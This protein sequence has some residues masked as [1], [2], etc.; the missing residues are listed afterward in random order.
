MKRDKEIIRRNSLFRVLDDNI[1]KK[2]IT[3][4]APAGYGKTTLVSS[5]L[6]HRSITGIWI[7]I[8]AG[9][10]TFSVFFN[11]FINKFRNEKP[12]FGENFLS[13]IAAFNT[14]SE[15]FKN[16]L[17]VVQDLLSL[18]MEDLM[19]YF[20]EKV[21][22]VLDDFHL[23]ENQ[24][25]RLTSAFFE[26]LVKENIG[27]LQIFITSRTEPSVGLNR[28]KAKRELLS[29]TADDLRFTEQE[30]YE[31]AEKCY[32]G[33]AKDDFPKKLMHL[34]DGWVTGLHLVLQSKRNSFSSVE[35]LS[36]VVNESLY[37]FFMEEI[38]TELDDETKDLLLKTSQLDVFTERH[39][40]EI[41]NMSNARNIISNLLKRNIFIIKNEDDN[42]ESGK[43][44]YIYNDYFRKFL[45]DQY[46]IAF[47]SE[48]K[49]ENERKIALYF[50]NMG[51]H[52]IAIDRYIKGKQY[53]EAMKLISVSYKT[54]KEWDKLRRIELWLQSVPEELMLSHPEIVYMKAYILLNL[55]FDVK[56]ACELIDSAIDYVKETNM[57][58]KLALL[59]AETTFNTYELEMISRALG[60]AEIMNYDPGLNIRLHYI[61][62]KL[63][64]RSGAANYENARNELLE[65]L[66]IIEETD[67]NELKPEIFMILGNICQDT[68]EFEK[69]F[70]YR[71]RSQEISKNIYQK[72]QV[73][74]NLAGLQIHTGKYEDAYSTLAE[75][76][77]L[78]KKNSFT[79]LKR[80]LVK[81]EAN[82]YYECGDFETCYEKFEELIKIENSMNLTGF[83]WYN[84][85]MQGLQLHYSDLQEYALQKFDIAESYLSRKDKEKLILV[86][87]GRAMCL[88]RKNAEQNSEL[89]EKKLLSV[90]DY[91]SQN[92]LKVVVLQAA[93][94]LASYYLKT[95]HTETSQKY[96]KQAF[97]PAYGHDLASFFERELPFHRD[98]FDL[99]VT[100]GISRTLR[101]KV[102][103]SYLNRRQFPWISEK[104]RNRLAADAAKLTDLKLYP[105]GKAEIYLRGK[106]ISEEKWIRKKSKILLIFLMSDPARIHTKDE[107]MD[108][109]FD[110]MPA[111][112]ADVVY[113]S[114]IY[115]IR[116]A[117]RIYDIKSSK[118]KRSRD[119]S[120]DYNPQYILYEDKTLKLNPDF[121]YKTDNIEFEKFYE[122]SKLPVLAIEDK[123]KYSMSAIELYKGD[124]LPGY[125]DSW[126]EELRVKYK[127]M[128]ITLCEDLIKLLEAE[129]RFDEVIKYSELLLKE[130]KLND[131]AHFS[132][133]NAYTKLGN[134]NMA[135]SRFDLMLK[136]YA[137]ELGENPQP[138]TL[139]KIK[140][141]LSTAKDP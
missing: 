71:R 29:L 118:P 138:R 127:N 124:F 32:P 116:T 48:Q 114:A 135:K 49:K 85:L 104:C 98:L 108:I 111:D 44:E 25:S 63:L 81:T 90:Y 109:F 22:L 99:S 102:C 121:Y 132:L 91:Y 105:F 96:L 37:G 75:M 76:K 58:L 28:L 24:D 73:C 10:R 1:S 35:N 103:G 27:N 70:F 13:S 119:K 80:F 62:G 77:I 38:W 11:H 8:T 128:Y 122:N 60:T 65:A 89:I 20:S 21:V 6:N 3:V 9:N 69:S 68:G 61:R 78:Y 30:T 139:E 82:L 106:P 54:P 42:E 47:P 36:D 59:K 93:F 50:Q 19:N 83:L 40:I 129:T 112:K 7:G 34:L 33:K 43:T 56:N 134:M 53:R 64:Y 57:K 110:D 72:M 88:L 41:Y 136:I 92:N 101:R 84:Y 15:L 79:S 23:L 12:G 97:D 18:F 115:N 86:N 51:E 107:I 17:S 141:I 14:S 55:N 67:E 94:Y 130:D 2:V 120:F 117:L 16:P 87:Q 125:Y 140:L 100:A 123:I 113:H 5:Y 46:E 4:I 26:A 74:S 137:E 95:N 39:C 31:L 66:K 131:S 133:I 52:D 45:L 126:C